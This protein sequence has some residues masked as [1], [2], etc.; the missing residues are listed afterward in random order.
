MRP[1]LAL[2]L[3][4]LSISSGYADDDVLE[5]SAA[6]AE[7]DA[8]ESDGDEDDTPRRRRFDYSRFSDGP[9][10]VPTPRGASAQRARAL[11]LGTRES[12]SR[13][14]HQRPRPAWVEAA[15]EAGPMPEHLRWP[16]DLGRFGRGFGYVRRRRPNLPHR[17]IDIVADEGSPIRAVAPGIVAY[18]DNGIRGFGNA[19]I[20]VHPDGSA[21]LYAHCVRTTVQPGWRV[22]AGE[23][24]GFVGNTGISRGDH[25]H[26]EW[27]ENGRA[28]NPLPKFD[29]RP[30]IAAYRSWDRL[31]R[32][33]RYREP[34]GYLEPNLPS[35]GA[36][37]PRAP[38]PTV[39]GDDR[40]GLAEA[41][42]LLDGGV[43]DAD[44]EAVEGRI[45][46]NVLWPVRGGARG[47]DFRQARGINV[48]TN[49][50]SPVRAIADGQVIYA[51]VGLR[52]V[53]KAIV[54]LHKNGWVSLYG[55]NDTLNV[56]AGQQVQRGE[57]IAR[58]GDESDHL[59]RVPLH[60]LADHLAA[61][62]VAFRKADVE[63]IKEK[64]G[65]TK[66]LFYYI[67]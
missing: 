34:S 22:R 47:S 42:R 23:R 51:G 4:M 39:R 6:E 36:A 9:R 45:F 59:Q 3:C 14:L 64:L 37:P 46:S 7:A 1:L 33:G 30:W 10:F 26:F 15:R 67:N 25:L 2:A 12:A 13:L 41:Q 35:D 27:H 20:L 49:T 52:G 40:E 54:I 57:W 48:S 66:R 16:V 62:R 43:R 17:G 19:V 21:S 5:G 31:K 63:A 65:S 24:I 29:G 18:S 38:Q 50:S 11:G 32:S 53:G 60:R 44:L 58:V 28:T 8:A 55:A 61:L 56:E